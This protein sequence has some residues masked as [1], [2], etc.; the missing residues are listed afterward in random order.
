MTDILALF[1]VKEA[2]GD[3]VAV[4]L[5]LKELGYTQVFVTKIKTTLSNKLH[6]SNM[7]GLFSIRLDTLYK[8]FRQFSEAAVGV[9][10]PF[11]PQSPAID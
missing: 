7:M 3:V 2:K 11:V 5:H 8:D 10:V 1:M 9:V 4:Y 6:M